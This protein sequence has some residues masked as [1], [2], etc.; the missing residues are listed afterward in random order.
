[1]FGRKKTL[2]KIP[3]NLLSYIQIEGEAIKDA[4]DKQMIVSYAY[5]K[6]EKVDWYIE[7]LTVGSNKYT[8]PHTLEQLSGI[9]QQ[10]QTLIKKIM[11]TPIPSSSSSEIEI[12]YPKGYEG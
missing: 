3:Y 6:L 4:N 9:K 5:S 7:L 10:L 2:K 12:K 1:M 8:V 11:D